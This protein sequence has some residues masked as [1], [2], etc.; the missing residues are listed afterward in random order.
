MRSFL[1]ASALLTAAVA[2]HASDASAEARKIRLIHNYVAAVPAVLRERGFLEQALA[3]RNV[4]VEW[5]TALGSNKTFEFLRGGNVDFG[6]SGGSA[7]LVAR[8]N[9]NPVKVL[10][11]VSHGELMALATLPNSGI[12]TPADLKGRKVAATRGTEPHYFLL[13]GLEQ[14]GLTESDIKLVPLIDPD[15]RQ[16]LETGNVDAWAGLD[17]DLAKVE[18]QRGAIRFYRNP[19]ILTGS[20]LIVRDQFLKDNPELTAIVLRAHEDARKWIIAHPDET[21]ELIAK[22]AKITLEEAKVTVGRLDFEH[23]EITESDYQKIGAF[24][25]LLKKVGDIPASTDVKAVLDQVLDPVPFRHA[26]GA[27]G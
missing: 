3:G 14:Y 13:R 17:P 8:A 2:L 11:F 9:G 27:K 18:L 20:V 7:A 26:V 15:G 5:V 16:A 24:G 25:D 10:S 4:E 12:K 21:A 1:F 22:G 6:S 19:E 23:P